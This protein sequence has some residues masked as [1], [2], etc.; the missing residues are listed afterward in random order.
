MKTAPAS[1]EDRAAKAALFSRFTQLLPAALAFDA[2]AAAARV[3][4][5]NNSNP[6]SSR[7][8][9]PQAVLSPD[10]DAADARGFATG[11][12][13]GM[14]GEGGGPSGGTRSSLVVDLLAVMRDVVAAD[15]APH[16]SLFRRAPSYY[17][18][19]TRAHR[20]RVRCAN[21]CKQ[22]KSSMY[23]V[24]KGRLVYANETKS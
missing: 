10:A 9:L 21:V 17:F 1:E 8:L 13:G 3:P 18:H 12:P 14:T 2:D 15:R 4:P 23:P 6:S 5:R 22:R 24:Q 16:Q 11:N 7:S 20:L 19:D